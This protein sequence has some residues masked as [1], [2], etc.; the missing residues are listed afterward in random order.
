MFFCTDNETEKENNRTI[1]ANLIR[2]VKSK[3]DACTSWLENTEELELPEISKAILDN[4]LADSLCEYTR[5]QVSDGM[6]NPNELPNS[7]LI[8]ELT[9]VQLKKMVDFADEASGDKCY[10][11]L[12]TADYES[13]LKYMKCLL[14][15]E[16]IAEKESYLNEYRELQTLY[17]VFDDHAPINIY[18]QSF[19]L[20]LT[21]FDAVVFDMATKLFSS[22]FFEIAPFINYDKKFTLSSIGLYIVKIKDIEY[23]KD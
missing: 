18:R 23:N 8:E 6:D 16:E 15:N 21:A 3:I 7:K 22:K 11:M 4:D 9:A 19:I 20:L 1:L 17:S 13:I 12:E 14:H 10:D 2:L 5:L